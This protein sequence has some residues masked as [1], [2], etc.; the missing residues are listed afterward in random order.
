MKLIKNVLHKGELVDIAVEN[1]KIAD[2]GK[3]TGDGVDFGG[4]KIYPG[5]IDTHSHGCI[6]KDT[7]DADLQEMSEYYLKCGT[8]TWYPTTMT[9]SKED[10]VRATSVDLSNIRGANIPGFHLEGPFI[11]AKYKGAQNERFVIPPTMELIKRCKKVKKITLAPESEGALDFIRECPAVVSIGHSTCDYDTAR[12]AFAAGAKCLTHTFNCMS[13]MHHR[14]PGPIPAGAECGAYAE[15]IC[16]GVH[17]H[18]AMIRLLC[19]LYGKRRI[20]LISDSV[21]A[22]GMPDGVYELGGLPIT[23]TDGKAYTEGGNLAGSTATLFYCV[24]KAVEFGIPEED[25][26]MMATENPARLMGLRRKGKIKIGYDADFII[27]D[28]DFNLIASIARGE[29]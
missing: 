25:A 1:G 5:L 26:V 6:G 23:V 22:A 9:V 14:A 18:P 10:I 12:A 3:L 4:A 7:M 29:F 24:K 11:N 28:N 20:V 17:I 8:T 16:D 19:K 15:V 21:R 2:I 13:P 27:V